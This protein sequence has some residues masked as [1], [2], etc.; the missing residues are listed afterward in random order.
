MSCACCTDPP[1]FLPRL[2][3][4]YL[5]DGPPSTPVPLTITVESTDGGITWA[6]TGFGWA[7]LLEVAL[8][9]VTW[10]FTAS[11]GTCSYSGV[12]V[13]PV[14]CEMPYIIPLTGTGC[15]NSSVYL[16]PGG[17]MCNFPCGVW[18]SQP[19]TS[20]IGPFSDTIHAILT[21]HSGRFFNIN[22][23]RVTMTKQGCCTWTG[24]ITFVLHPD[25]PL[26]PPIDPGGGG[27]GLPPPVTT[28]IITVTVSIGY[29]FGFPS[30][31]GEPPYCI[32]WGTT[33][34]SATG[35][36]NDS[37]YDGYAYR[38]FPNTG[39]II[40][41]GGGSFYTAATCPQTVAPTT[42]ELLCSPIRI[43]GLGFNS[44]CDQYSV[45]ITEGP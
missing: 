45:L 5:P 1:C 42:L 13:S 36:G 7:V 26:P 10:T 20:P 8:D 34:S 12:Y 22:G 25:P 39:P 40:T 37:D 27:G 30:S 24:T 23:Q 6:G 3:C 38:L 17:C 4:I 2:I 33:S 9:F 14:Y 15:P 41:F 28:L 21:D 44:Q 32:W 18:I 29:S 11:N 31:A 35:G 16:N 19:T 43:Q